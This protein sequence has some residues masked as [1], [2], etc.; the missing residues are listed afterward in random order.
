MISVLQHRS[1]VFIRQK[2]SGEFP[3]ELQTA[4]WTGKEKFLSLE[5]T[6]NCFLSAVSGSKKPA[7]TFIHF[8][9]SLTNFH[10]LF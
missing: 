2:E 5:V 3:G 10:F 9:A 6:V 7:L 4:L 8:V 1:T